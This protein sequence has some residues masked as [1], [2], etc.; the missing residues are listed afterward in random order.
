VSRLLDE[1]PEL[2]AAVR[3]RLAEIDARDASR[4]DAG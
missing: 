3:E 2:A 4:G 1:R